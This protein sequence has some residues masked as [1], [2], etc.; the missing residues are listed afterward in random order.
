[1]RYWSVMFVLFHIFPPRLFVCLPFLL[2]FCLWHS[3]LGLIRVTSQ[4]S[5]RSV[6]ISS[7]LSVFPSSSSLCCCCV[8]HHTTALPFFFSLCVP[9]VF[10]LSLVVWCAVFCTHAHCYLDVTP[11]LFSSLSIVCLVMIT[12]FQYSFKVLHFANLLSV[13]ECVDIT[14]WG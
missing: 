14:E 4:I 9:P 10:V 3:K 8:V 12:L 7:P 13:F 1:M 6:Y 11:S 5:L 2:L